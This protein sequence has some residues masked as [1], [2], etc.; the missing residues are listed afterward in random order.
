MAITAPTADL[1]TLGTTVR[2]HPLRLVL[3]LDELQTRAN[4]GDAE[5]IAFFEAQRLAANAGNN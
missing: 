2:L 3:V 5:A 1:I 4:N